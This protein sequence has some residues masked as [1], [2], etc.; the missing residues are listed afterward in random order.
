MHLDPED[1]RARQKEILEP[2]HARIT[3]ELDRR[4]EVGRSTI[5]VAMHSFTPVFKGV[6]RPWQIGVLYHRDARFAHAL[7]ALLE[8]EGDLTVGDNE[9]YAV[10]DLTDYTIPV[11]GERRAIPHV[12]IEIRQDLIADPAGQRAWAARLTR[13]LPEAWRKLSQ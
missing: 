4:Q 10:G 3:N 9:P 6:A 2:Y 13:L 5:L 7:K 11:H 12:E 1:R 8:A